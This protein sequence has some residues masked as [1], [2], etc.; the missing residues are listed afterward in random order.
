MSGRRRGQLLLDAER[1]PDEREWVQTRSQAGVVFVK[2]MQEL[3]QAGAVVLQVIPARSVIITGTA[4]CKSKQLDKTRRQA[5][6]G[7]LNLEAPSR[8]GSVKRLSILG[9]PLLRGVS[10]ESL[11]AP[12]EIKNFSHCQSLSL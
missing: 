12:R 1:K 11:V 6:Q 7:K 10:R 8:Y 3:R 2:E 4:G 9:C 5:H